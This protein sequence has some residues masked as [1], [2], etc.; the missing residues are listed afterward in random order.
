MNMLSYQHLETNLQKHVDSKDA[1]T[2]STFIPI[3]DSM[4]SEMDEGHTSSK[5]MKQ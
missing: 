5:L 2:K 4:I 3:M 1:V